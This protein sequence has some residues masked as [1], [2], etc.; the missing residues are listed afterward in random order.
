MKEAVEQFV[1]ESRAEET[2]S[3][4]GAPIIPIPKS[5]GSLRICM[6]YHSLNAVTPQ[7]QCQIPMLDDM[8]SKIG[9]AKF[10]IKMDLQKWFY[11]IDLEESSR[12]YTAFVTPTLLGSMNY[13]R[14]TM[15][16]T[17]PSSCLLPRQRPSGNADGLNR[18]SWEQYNV[19]DWESSTTAIT[20]DAVNDPLS[21]SSPLQMLDLGAGGCA[22]IRAEEVELVMEICSFQMTAYEL[23]HITLTYYI[24]R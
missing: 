12:D 11:Q 21:G 13:Y 14:Q 3:A 19:R 6:D 22:G 23:H 18:Q 17:L 24:T 2:E 10:L 8:L 1:T 7:L 20:I 16:T 15:P 4:W 5:D 9:N